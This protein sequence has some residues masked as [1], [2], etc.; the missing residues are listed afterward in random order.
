M[1]EVKDYPHYL[2]YPKLRRVMT[3]ADRIRAMNDDEFPFL[4][5]CYYLPNL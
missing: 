3:N 2:D 5:L 4:G 1:N